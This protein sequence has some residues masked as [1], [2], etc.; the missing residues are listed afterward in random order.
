MADGWT[1]K[2]HRSL[3][4]F[5]VYCPAGTCFVRS[6]DASGIIKTAENLFSLFSEVIEWVGPK[7]V[8]HVVTDNAANYVSADLPHVSSL[9]KRA[10]KVTVFVYN[11]GS[12]LHWLKQR[13]TWKE[14]VRP[15]ATRFATTFFTLSSILER[16]GDLQALVISEFF[17]DSSFYKT[18]VGKEVKSIIL[19][20]KFWDDCMFIVQLT[21]PIVKL[22]RIVDSDSKPALGYV[23]EGMR[24]VEDGVKTVCGNVEA[25]YKPYIDIIE[26]RWDKHLNR[27]LILAAYFFNPAL[28]YSAGFDN[29]R[30]VSNALFNIF[31]NRA[32]CSLSD[33]DKAIDEMGLYEKGEGVFGRSL[34]QQGSQH[35]QPCNYTLQLH[36]TFYFGLVINMSMLNL[37]KYNCMVGM[38]W[39]R[40]SDNTEVGH[41]YC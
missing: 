10:S 36:F 23:H 19:D 22:L 12:I 39:Q 21:I 30:H 15:A 4:N 38:V 35:Q 2:R 31:E 7:N 28:R 13:S 20:Q 6:I 3:I 25:E 33:S 1:D 17:R 29:S 34:A 40:D 41:P 26:A 5:L 14:I 16:Q 32:I 9:A 27:D 37:L 11:H 24:R 8:V 18:D